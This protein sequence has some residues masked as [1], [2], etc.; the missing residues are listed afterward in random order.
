[1]STLPPASARLRTRRPLMT[2]ATSTRSRSLRFR[3]LRPRSPLEPS[4]TL[5]PCRSESAG[6]PARRGACSPPPPAAAAAF[7]QTTTPTWN[8]D[9]VAWQ[10]REPSE[11]LQRLPRTRPRGPHR[12]PPRRPGRGVARGRARSWPPRRRL[13]LQGRAGAARR[14]VPRL[15]GGALRSETPKPLHAQDTAVSP[16]ANSALRSHRS[17]I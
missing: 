6:W 12:L 4:A 2:R 5:L 3:S 15:P 17:A 11:S 8:A 14:G 7:S 10:I 13:R 9:P 1:V 16:S